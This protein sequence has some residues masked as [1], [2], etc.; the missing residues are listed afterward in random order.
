[1]QKE[2]LS[3]VLDN[4]LF[5][6]S[7]LDA[8]KLS[9]KIQISLKET[10]DY[11][12]SRPENWGFIKEGSSVFFAHEL[13]RD[14]IDDLHESFWNWYLKNVPSYS[15]LAWEEGSAVADTSRIKVI[16]QPKIIVS[17]L[18]ETFSA[19]I[20]I[21][22]EDKTGKQSFVYALTGES[23]NRPAPGVYF[24]KINRSV[25]DFNIDFECIILDIPPDSP[26]WI[27]AKASFGI[28]LAY[29][30]TEL[31]TFEKLQYW[32]DTFLEVYSYDLCP[33]I[34]LLG[35][36]IDLLEKRE[37]NEFESVVEL[38]REQL[39]ANYGT[40]VVSELVSLTEGTNV[41]NTFQN[42]TKIIRQWYQIIKEE[43]SDD[44]P[45]I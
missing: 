14:N 2:E 31:Q 16:P 43:Y 38:L 8:E 25:D 19:R 29:D 20:V 17:G 12:F 23:L 39:E 21:L 24:G 15:D 1:M 40:I 41:Q 35:T 36:K 4:Y 44:N 5:S 3:E 26:L 27:Y 10:K 6:N 18:V 37:L 13:I 22:G 34:L 30:V 9:K 42:F 33:P 11:F 28:V 32:L 45:V 7:H